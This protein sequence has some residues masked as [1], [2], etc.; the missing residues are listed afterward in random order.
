M[1]DRKKCVLH[2]SGE[3]LL[4]ESIWMAGV[5]VNWSTTPSIKLLPISTGFV[6][7]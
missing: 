3:N 6:L 5:K 1:V 4:A 7:K 2:L